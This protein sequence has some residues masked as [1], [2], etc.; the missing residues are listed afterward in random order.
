MISALFICTGNQYRSP[1]A[2]EALRRQLIRDHRSDQWRVSSAGTWTSPG[3]RSPRAAIELARSVGVNIERHVTRMVDEKMLEDADLV[4]VMEQGHRESIQTE[5]PF[6][7]KK[8]YLLSQVVHEFAH[9]IPDPAGANGN[10]GII[11]RDLVEMIR[12][13]HGKIYRIAESI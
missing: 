6:A 7:R 12:L 4:F 8:L 10:A 13:G 1:I 2:A 9:D 3:R 5:F 11:I